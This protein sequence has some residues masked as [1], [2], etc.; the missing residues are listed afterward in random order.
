MRREAPRNTA[1]N[2]DKKRQLFGSELI[3]LL[4]I[5][6]HFSYEFY[7]LAFSFFYALSLLV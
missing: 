4:G 6:N 5:P 3:R 2:L 7:L 1:D